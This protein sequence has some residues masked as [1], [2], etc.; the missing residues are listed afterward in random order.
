MVF[1]PR[2]LTIGAELIGLQDH[3]GIGVQDLD[4]AAVVEQQ[5]DI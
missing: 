1:S 5:E 3:S 4:R 2:N